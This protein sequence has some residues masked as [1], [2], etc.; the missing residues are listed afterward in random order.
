MIRSIRH[1]AL[2]NFHFKGRPK[3]LNADHLR[4]IRLLL[5]HLEVIESPGEMDFP[6]SGYHTLTGDRQGQYSL[7]ISRNWRMVFEWDGENVVN[8]D[9]VDYH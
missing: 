4:R 9:L 1:K 8:V 6:G 3:G 7:T 5:D 2:G